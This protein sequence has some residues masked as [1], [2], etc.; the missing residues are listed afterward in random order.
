MTASTRIA[1]VVLCLALG[2]SLATAQTTP[3]PPEPLLGRFHTWLKGGSDDLNAEASRAWGTD[4]ERYLA[5]EMYHGS[6]TGL[7]LG[8]E[9]GHSGAGKG[10]TDSGNPVRD[11]DFWWLELNEKIAFDAH[12]G[13]T[14]DVGLGLA[15]F[16]VEGQEVTTQG[17]QEFTD[18]LADVG[19]GAQVLGDF[20]WRR[21]HLLLG[22][23]AR[24]QQ[25]FDV[26][27]INYSNLRLGAHL[28]LVF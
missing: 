9:L 16:Y 15:L 21:R 19:L 28:G 23:D 13:L 3:R 6:P 25:A 11:L 4:H 20:N 26:I 24:Y 5:L 27:N 14:F 22:L 12:H 8:G 18:P 1:P 10:T 17:G 7:Y 2:G